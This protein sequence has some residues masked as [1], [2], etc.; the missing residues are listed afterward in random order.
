MTRT[1]LNF[2][3]PIQELE[4]KIEQFKLNFSGDEEELEKELEKFNKKMTKTITNVFSNLS[5]WEIVQIARHPQRPYT[6]DYIEMIVDGFYELHGDRNYRDDPSIIGGLRKIGDEKFVIIGHQKGRGTRQKIH[7][8]FGMAHPE[9]Y[10]KAIR[11]MKLGEKFNIPILTL[12]DT[13]GAY[14]GIGAEERG[15]AEAIARNLREMSLLKVPT[16]SC[17]I[18]EGGSG[19]A[20]G[21]GVTDIILML[22]F[23][24]Y[25]VI[26]PE[27]CASILFRDASRA[28][29]SATA[30]KLTAIDLKKLNIIDE[31]L[32]EPLGCA[33]CNPNETAK[34]VKESIL[35]YV[36]ELK[37]LTVNELLDKRY[38][39]FKNIGVYKA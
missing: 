39:K 2:E 3:K 17:V 4:E 23:S 10:R 37:A 16:I 8:N 34:L 25:S 11:L 35:K 27:G 9:G 30:L 7:R 5:P 29:E 18:G 31:I 33:H 13:P 21:I 22:Q 6:S 19:G 24:V 1:Y 38:Q 15:Q 28:K 32:P 20:L 36:K 14:P 26:S 12:I